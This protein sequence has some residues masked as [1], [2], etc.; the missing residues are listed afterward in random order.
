MRAAFSELQLPRLDE[1][2]S[3]SLGKRD[4]APEPVRGK[5]LR[6]A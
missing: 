1:L 2:A 6:G 4:R 5:A 3:S